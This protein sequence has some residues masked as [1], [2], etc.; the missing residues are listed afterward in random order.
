MML[1]ILQSPNTPRPRCRL[2]GI[3]VA[4][5]GLVLACSS[6]AGPAY[7]SGGTEAFGVE[8]FESQ[9]LTKEGEPATQ[10]GSHPYEWK[11][12]IVLNHHTVEGSVQPNEEAQN[13]DVNLPSGMIVNPTATVVRCQ[14]VELEQTGECPN[15]S[16][17]GED[18]YRFGILGGVEGTSKVYNMET[19]PSAPAELGFKAVFEGITV[20]ILGKVRTATDY[21]LSSEV[22]EVN[23]KIH[24]WANAITLYGETEDGQKPFLTLPTSCGA[25][26]ITTMTANSWQDPLT[27]LPEV[28]VTSHDADG[29]PLPVTGC[30]KLDFAPQLVVRP[31]T[32]AADSPSGLSVEMTVPQEESFTNLA[33]ADLKEAAVTLPAGMAVSPA[34]AD[35]G[36]GA[37]TPQQ[38]G[39]GEAGSPSCPPSSKVGTVEIVTPLL[40]QPLEGAVY[41]AQQGTNLFPR[42]GSNPFGSLIALYLVVEGKGV[43][44][45]VP[46]EVSLDP[47]TGQLTTHFGEDPAVTFEEA[48]V[49]V[50]PFLPQLPFSH[51]KL[52]FFGGA[53]AALVTPPTCGTYAVT[54]SLIPYSAPESG[55]SATPSSNFKINE[56]CNG[57]K[58]TPL[59]VAGTEDNQAGGFSP[60][61]VR[62][63]RPE[64]LEPEQDVD[65]IQ[66]RTP[67]GLLGMVSS[68]TPCEEPQAVNGE[69]GQASLIGHVTA[70]VGAG[71]D[72]LYVT[73]EVFL[74]GPYDGAPYGLSIVVP[75]VAGP[76]NLGVVKVRATIEVNPLTAALTVT[77][78]PLPQ[79]LDGIR[80][81]IRTVDVDV[82]REHFI[83]N[84]TN[85]APTSIEAMVAST[86]GASASLSSRFQAANCTTLDFAPKFSVTVSG[87]TSHANGTS[88]DAKIFYPT[89]P[90]ANIARI[91]VELPKQL[92]ARLKTL[93][94]ACIAAVFEANPASCPAASV[95][96]IARTTTPVLPGTLSG[97][98]YF[99][100]HGGEA[101]P[102]L[103]VV[104]QG[105]GVRADLVGSTFI[106]K[107]N[108]TSSTFKGIPDVPVSTFELY[109]PEGP[110]SA[111]DANGDLCMSSLAMPTTF[112]AQNGAKI[113]QRTPISVS[114]C[115]KRRAKVKKK[116]GA[117]KAGRMAGSHLPR[118]SE[119]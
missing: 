7:A 106:S 1:W 89:G 81:Q 78:D 13:I 83:F 26:L 103:D 115:P 47:V 53:R 85:C 88:L 79:I 102:D 32:R 67:P 28:S 18:S 43:V 36:L 74:T 69:C 19:P 63:S 96:G 66:V 34:A 27:Y 10:A 12:G 108:I 77:S 97:P 20:H 70:G 11:V 8:A 40:E 119:R 15:L 31:T 93:Q 54:S 49:K 23:Q 24:F 33:E 4:V 16:V 65:R 39:L 5:M 75:A 55:P 71:P 61:T 42:E 2:F 110:D 46:G 116:M 101:F 72:S 82:D 94:K 9:I 86:L 92:A 58:F 57:G 95:V 84:P 98:V 38:I 30:E 118:E 17:V 76:F 68:V 29:D 44:I 41:L 59:L 22:P 35:G 105:D 104:L 45:K 62:L 109:L 21:G 114:G 91:K 25:P 3:V 100:S 113:R 51:L 48:G 80:L 60:F 64:A 73:G 117:G 37:C 6:H 107:S 90:N 111:L 56:R 52:D 50:H 112:V 99:V 87:R 14:E